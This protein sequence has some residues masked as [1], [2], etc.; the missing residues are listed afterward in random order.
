MKNVEETQLKSNLANYSEDLERMNIP[1]SMYFIASKISSHLSYVTDTEILCHLFKA[2]TVA[3][4]DYHN[5]CAFF[6]MFEVYPKLL[7]S[8]PKTLKS[9]CSHILQDW[10]TQTN[11]LEIEKAYNIKPLMGLSECWNYSCW[12]TQ[13]SQNVINSNI[14]LKTLKHKYFKN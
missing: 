8:C 14:D 9:C 2:S 13:T 1:V 7:L 3:T 10:R 6:K 12:Y 5:S 11:Q 4:Y